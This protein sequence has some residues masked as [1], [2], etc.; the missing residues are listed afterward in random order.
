MPVIS[1]ACKQF[2]NVFYGKNDKYLAFAWN[3]E[4][5]LGNALVHGCEIGGS[6]SDAVERLAVRIA[7]EYL[8]DLVANEDSNLSDAELQ[9]T[10]DKILN[11]YPPILCGARGGND[12]NQFS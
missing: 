10:V 9:K 1:D 4:D 6:T 2:Q 7:R 8:T 3:R 12:D 11:F 5:Q